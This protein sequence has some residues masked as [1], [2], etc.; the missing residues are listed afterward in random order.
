MTTIFKQHFRLLGCKKSSLPED[1]K[2]SVLNMEKKEEKRPLQW[3]NQTVKRAERG[4]DT[5]KS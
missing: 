1:G 5:K 4:K 3:I 2:R